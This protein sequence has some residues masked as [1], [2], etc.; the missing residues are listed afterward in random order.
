MQDTVLQASGIRMAY[1]RHPV[2]GGADLRVKRGEVCGLLG[3]NGSGKT[4][5][6]KIITGLTRPDAGEVALFGEALRPPLLRRVGSIIQ[7]QGFYGGKTATETLRTHQ[8]LLGI[9]DD[10]TARLLEM[11]GLSGEG[12]KRVS[13]FSTGMKQRLA[14]AMALSGS[15][16]LLVLD[17]PVNGLDAQGMYDIRE[18]LATL[19]REDGVTILITSHLLD[20]VSRIATCYAFLKDGVLRQVDGDEIQRQSRRYAEIVT[21]DH[22]AT[23]VALDRFVEGAGGY[24]VMPDGSFR[25]YHELDRLPEINRALVEAG[26]AVQGLTVRADSLVDYYLAETG[27]GDERHA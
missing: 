3:P 20:E 23:A 16:D 22:A 6:L 18:V 5:L 26:I 9:P 8:M 21:D 1:K 19:N 13:R 17:E 12:G 2:L 11:V 25:L 10:R 14:I 27:K 4:T 7:K 15:P 24:E